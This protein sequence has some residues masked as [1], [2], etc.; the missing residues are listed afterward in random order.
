LT[1][2]GLR[3]QRAEYAVAERSF[4]DIAARAARRNDIALEARA[5]WGRTLSLARR[6]AMA[7]GESSYVDAARQFDRIGEVRNAAFLKTI[8]SEIRHALGRED[9]SDRDLYEALSGFHA[10]P[11]PGQRYALLLV[12][13][14]RLSERGLQ[15]ASAAM[16]RE[17]VLEAGLTGRE[18]DLPEALTR[19]ASAEASIGDVAAAKRT[20]ARIRELL[21]SIPD[22]VMHSRLDAELARTEARVY[23][24]EDRTLAVDRL[25]KAIS[26]FAATEIPTDEANLRVERAGLLLSLGDSAAAERDLAGATSTAAMY[27]GRNPSRAS[28][29]VWLSTQ[30]QAYHQLVSIALARGDTNRAYEYTRS[31]RKGSVDLARGDAVVIEYVVLDRQTLIWTTSGSTRRLTVVPAGDSTLSDLVARFTNLIRQ[32]EDTLAELALGRR[33]NELL[34]A[35]VRASIRE[36]VVIVPDGPLRGLPFAALRDSSGQYLIE[37]VAL[38][39][40]DGRG[41]QG[42]GADHRAFTDALFVGSPSWDRGL[43]PDL[44][45]LREVEREVGEASAQYPRRVILGDSAA[46]RA[47]IVKELSLHDV[48]HFAGHARVVDD[49]PGASHLVLAKQPGGFAANVLSATEIAAMRLNRVRLVVLSACG[50]TGSRFGRAASNGLAEAFLDAGVGSVIAN[51]WEADDAGA[52]ALTPVLHRELRNGAAADEALR[53]AQVAMLSSGERRF[54]APAVWSGFRV[55]SSEMPEK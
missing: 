45:P 39:Y 43:F 2:A 23:E 11:R 41:G 13:G 51:D 26:Y 15:Y 46:N 35:P 27:I 7:D 44:E 55:V 28:S 12:V 52:A 24:G 38:A 3:I 34:V 6:G 40:S 47:G 29:R 20:I 16:I 1:L 32:N 4:D 10:N 48:V 22:S 54:S 25:G 36:R 31:D 14:V 42:K 9:A 8:I 49:N 50:S 30:R 17:A 18:K 19:L 53:R 33:L 21:P 5:R 37:D